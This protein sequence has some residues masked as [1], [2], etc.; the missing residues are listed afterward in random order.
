[1]PADHA[2]SRYAIARPSLSSAFSKT[3]IVPAIS[4]STRSRFQ[5]SGPPP[6]RS[7]TRSSTSDARAAGAGKI[8][9]LSIASCSTSLASS[10]RPFIEEGLAVLRQQPQPAAALGGEQRSGAAEQ[11]DGARHVAAGECP[12]SRR[13]E[14]ARPLL[15]DLAAAG[16]ERPELREVVAGLLQVVAEDLLEL[17][18]AVLVGDVGPCDEA[19]VQVGPRSFEDAVV[20]GV[21]DHDVV[22]TVRALLAV[23]E[24]AH[25]VL[26]LE[27]DELLAD[28]LRERVGNEHAER[29]RG[30]VVADDGGGLDHRALVARERVQARGEQRLD[31]RGHGHLGEVA[32][33]APLAVLL[34]DQPLVGE[35]PQEL[36]DVERVALGR[37]DDPVEDALVEPCAAE[38]RL[39]HRPALRLAER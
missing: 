33:G 18:P 36:L 6:V 14:P 8:V 13:G 16:V 28:G 10:K 35:H 38:E 29:G 21:A 25:Q 19:L 17:R 30:E 2:R 32:G 3:R 5:P 27:R 4:S 24:P 12:S 34:L 22:E 15:A 31:R 39:D 26:R 23:L 20:G 9:E 1:M 7:R 37:L 11:G